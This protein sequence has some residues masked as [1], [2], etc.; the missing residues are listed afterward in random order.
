MVHKFKEV[1]EV[2]ELDPHLI[3][4]ALKTL[5]ELVHH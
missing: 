4:D 2:R 5:N 3:R 1:L